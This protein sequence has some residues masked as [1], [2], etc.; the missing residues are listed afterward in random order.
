MAERVARDGFQIVVSVTIP[1]TGNLF[2]LAANRHGDVLF[3][4]T[5]ANTLTVRGR[6]GTWTFPPLT[7]CIVE[8]GKGLTI[9]P[10]GIDV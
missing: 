3:L 7:T 1:D 5:Y 6:G 10:F 8:N 4:M 9:T 2:A